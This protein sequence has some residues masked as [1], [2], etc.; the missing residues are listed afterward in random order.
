MWWR[1][2]LKEDENR[3]VGLGI[4]LRNEDATWIEWINDRNISIRIQCS[5][6]TK[7]NITANENDYIIFTFLS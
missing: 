5:H 6:H 7:T 1:I 4:P 3:K 2:F